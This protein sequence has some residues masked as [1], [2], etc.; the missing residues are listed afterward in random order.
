M[1]NVHNLMWEMVQDVQTLHAFNEW[2]IKEYQRRSRI[3]FDYSMQ[4][5][6]EKARVDRQKELITARKDAEKELI[7]TRG[8][9]HR[10]HIGNRGQ[11]NQVIQNERMNHEAQ[12]NAE[13]RGMQYQQH[14]DRLNF[15]VGAIQNENQQR[16]AHAV[17]DA[18]VRTHMQN[19]QIQAQAAAQER[20]AVHAEARQAEQNFHH[21]N[22]E[23]MRI[24]ARNAFAELNTTLTERLDRLHA[25]LQQQLA[26]FHDRL[27]DQRQVREA[28]RG[29]RVWERAMRAQN[30]LI[31]GLIAN[32]NVDPTVQAMAYNMF[33]NYAQRLANLPQ[34]EL[35]AAE[36]DEFLN[37]YDRGEIERLIAAL[38]TP[39]RG[40]VDDALARRIADLENTTR[41]FIQMVSQRT[42]HV[43]AAQAYH[44]PRR[45]FVGRDG[46]AHTG[47]RYAR[48]GRRG[49]SRGRKNIPRDSK[50]RF[51][52]TVAR[53]KK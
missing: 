49:G 43:G 29:A 8:E 5:L 27:Q 33:A 9:W 24:D 48:G 39:R 53:V 41:N 25:G 34:N 22:M 4:N 17:A 47:N 31:A 15:Q 35:A 46:V 19:V 44:P 50:G 30:Q 11:V 2:M 51:K 36:G 7:Q 40:A 14:V 16:A 12:E 38:S 10:E 1:N 42:A 3:W 37:M 21:E 23:R 26:G 18:A 32:P 6:R 52:R 28:N 13:N 45:V 20:E